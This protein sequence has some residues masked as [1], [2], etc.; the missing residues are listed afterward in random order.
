MYDYIRRYYG[1]DPIPGERVL[2]TETRRR[3]QPTEGVI[4]P[5]DG[6]C[7]NYVMVRFD[8][9]KDAMP[10]HPTSLEYLGPQP[11]RARLGEEQG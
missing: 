11:A 2:F 9:E 7:G 5:E 1:V 4:H 3:G 10:C 6:S 8:G